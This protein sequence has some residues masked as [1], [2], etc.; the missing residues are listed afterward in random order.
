MKKIYVYLL[1]VA[2]SVGLAY[3]TYTIITM[4]ERPDRISAET[5]ENTLPAP[6]ETTE[7]DQETGESASNLSS[8]AV[9][10]KGYV[11]GLDPQCYTVIDRIIAYHSATGSVDPVVAMDQL[12]GDGQ[13]NTQHIE[14]PPGEWEGYEGIEIYFSKR[15]SN[16][17]KVLWTVKFSSG[18]TW[19]FT[20]IFENKENGEYLTVNPFDW[21]MYD[22]WSGDRQ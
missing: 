19:L 4:K 5:T 2:L 12:I 14:W 10:I 17:W 20:F 8:D 21:R 15:E 1:I 11:D 7:P 3:Q 6:M 22:V 16:Q 18:N 13:Y 9:T